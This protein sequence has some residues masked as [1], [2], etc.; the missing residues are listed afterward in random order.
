MQNF[1]SRFWCSGTHRWGGIHSDPA[2]AREKNFDPCMGILLTD[3]VVAAKLI[4]FR[5]EEPRDQSGGNAYGS[6]KDH[7]GSGVVFAVSCFSDKEKI[8]DGMFDGGSLDVEAISIAL[9]EMLQNRKNLCVRAHGFTSNVVREFRHLLRDPWYLAILT[10]NGLRIIQ[11][12][13]R[14]FVR[15][16]LPRLRGYGISDT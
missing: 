2:R 15:H 4:P 8:L 13:S 1:P 14:L 6:E 12:Q 11:Y 16:H 3:C 9:G 7:H 5:C 10:A